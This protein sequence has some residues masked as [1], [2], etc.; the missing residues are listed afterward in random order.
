MTVG[1]WQPAQRRYVLGPRGWP[2][3]SSSPSLPCP[4]S[5]L[6]LGRTPGVGSATSSR[7]GTPAAP[8]RRTCPEASIASPF[9]SHPLGCRWSSAALHPCLGLRKRLLKIGTKLF[10]LKRNKSSKRDVEKGN[11]PAPVPVGPCLAPE[12]SRR[13]LPDPQGHVALQTCPLLRHPRPPPASRRRLPVTPHMCQVTPHP[14]RRPP[15]APQVTA[16]SAVV[17][18]PGLP[19]R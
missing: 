3:P 15:A 11:S 19:Q 14:R 17:R 12:G 7:V 5:S 8:L 16:P 1:A 9:C 18:S 10:G 4:P 6:P 13:R 2:R